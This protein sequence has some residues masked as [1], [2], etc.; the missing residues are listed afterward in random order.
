MSSPLPLWT[1]LYARGAYMHTL[2]EAVRSRDLGELWEGTSR[3]DVLLEL[4]LLAGVDV[5]ELLRASRAVCD[6]PV[7]AGARRWAEAGLEALAA[8]EELAARF[9][10]GRVTRT[11]A[12]AGDAGAA[13]RMRADLEL[14]PIEEALALPVAA[15][16]TPEDDLAGIVGNFHR[17]SCM[18][19][20]RSA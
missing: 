13:H 16:P 20:T 18:G 17:P 6:G 8:D 15:R 19:A 2:D 7:L 14:A 11:L 12:I 5:G 3:A 1:Q 9:A 10:L 4:A